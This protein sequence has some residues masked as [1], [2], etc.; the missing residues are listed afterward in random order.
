MERW[1]Q[2]LLKGGFGISEL[3]QYYCGPVASDAVSDET[4]AADDTV[5]DVEPEEQAS[6]LGA[7]NGRCGRDV[8]RSIAGPSH[9]MVDVNRTRSSDAM[10]P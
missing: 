7:A 2:M 1:D 8:G 5:D 9:P 4:S 6:P 10:D 3:D